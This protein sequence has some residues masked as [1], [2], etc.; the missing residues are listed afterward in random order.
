M[1]YR[2]YQDFNEAYL[3]LNREILKN[4]SMVEYL[5]TTMGGIDNICLEVES[6]KCDKI[7]LGAL[8]YKIQ[9]WDHLVKTYLGPD[10]VE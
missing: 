3:G 5:N 10:N 4:P 6:P 7:D 2:K 9:K 1:V 8:G